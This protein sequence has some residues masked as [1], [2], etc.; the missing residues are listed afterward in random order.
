MLSCW[1]RAVKGAPEVPSLRWALGRWCASFAARE[2]DMLILL[3][4]IVH[5]WTVVGAKGGVAAVL[6]T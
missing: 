4:F 6:D 3:L 1:V 2:L 5:L